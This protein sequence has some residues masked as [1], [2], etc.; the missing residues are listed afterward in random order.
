VG[1]VI[2]SSAPL[3][4]GSDKPML[5]FTGLRVINVENFRGQQR[6]WH[7]MC[8]R[9]TCAPLSRAGSARLGSQN[10]D[11]EGAAQCGPRHQLQ[12]VHLY[13]GMD[14]RKLF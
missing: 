10:I 14:L 7:T 8:A 4:S 6:L 13:A 2:G 5:V 9:S 12:M 3:S 11:Q 1:G